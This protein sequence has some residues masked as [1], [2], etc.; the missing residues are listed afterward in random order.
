MTA[1]CGC[2]EQRNVLCPYH[3]GYSD[4]FDAG[5]DAGYDVSEWRDL[6]GEAT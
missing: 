4:G 2:D 5:Y 3:E 6:D 1:E